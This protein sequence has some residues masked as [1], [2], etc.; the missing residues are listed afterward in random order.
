MVRRRV[1]SEKRTMADGLRNVFGLQWSQGLRTL[2]DVRSLSS[3]KLDG[4]N[5]D[6]YRYQV[7]RAWERPIAIFVFRQQTWQELFFV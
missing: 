6:L 5:S 4:L 7:S 1:A 2:M 3:D